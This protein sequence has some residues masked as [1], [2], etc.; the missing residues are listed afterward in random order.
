MGKREDVK[1]EE[2]DSD[3]ISGTGGGEW[4]VECTRKR[5]TNKKRRTLRQA[6]HYQMGLAY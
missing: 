2:N 5:N 6:E 1:I 4:L 3:R